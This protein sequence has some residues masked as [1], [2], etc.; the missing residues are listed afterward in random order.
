MKT[1]RLKLIKNNEYAE[2]PVYNWDSI[3]PKN[4]LTIALGPP[5]E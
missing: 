4:N 1:G 3:S 5:L 2:R